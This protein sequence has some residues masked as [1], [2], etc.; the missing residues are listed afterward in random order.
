VCRRLWNFS[1]TEAARWHEWRQ[2]SIISSSWPLSR[3]CHGYG[4]LSVA[5][6]R[7]HFSVN[8]GSKPLAIAS[9]FSLTF[10]SRF[11]SLPLVKKPVRKPHF[12]LSALSH[13]K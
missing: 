13:S 9:V 8:P 2:C 4:V 1:Q 10:L 5:A 7:P 12:T 3:E 6:L 11:I